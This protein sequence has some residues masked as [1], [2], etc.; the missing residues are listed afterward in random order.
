MLVVIFVEVEAG[1]EDVAGS[2]IG[3]NL[4]EISKTRHR[5]LILAVGKLRDD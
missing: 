3:L 5:V 2:E 4:S 1:G